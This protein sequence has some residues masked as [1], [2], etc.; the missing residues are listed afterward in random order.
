[1]PE[2][3][4]NALLRM[5]IAG[6]LAWIVPGLGH[7]YLGHRTRGLI[8]LVTIS[9]T[10][11]TGVAIGGIRG[12]VDPKE[13]SLWFIAQLCTAGHTVSGYFL[14]RSVAT[15]SYPQDEA[16]P[17]P[18]WASVDVG[19]HY[20]GVAGLLNLLII[21]DAIARAESSRGSGRK[22][23]RPSDGDRH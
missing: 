20:T 2:R 1:M 6:F 14:H 11:W 15:E 10:F 21:F 19:V 18:N 23:G 5:P 13:R 12:T 17:A 16:P 4:P 22:N 8:L 9:V 3:K 7:I